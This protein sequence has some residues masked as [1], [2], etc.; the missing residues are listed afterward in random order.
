MSFSIFVLGPVKMSFQPS[1][2]EYFNNRKRPAVDDLKS[3]SNPSKVLIVDGA[4]GSVDVESPKS[5]GS[6]VHNAIPKKIVYTRKEASNLPSKKMKLSKTG[7]NSSKGSKGS[8]DGIQT[9][10]RKSL[11]ITNKKTVEKKENDQESKISKV[12]GNTDFYL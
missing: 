12:S 5:N 4:L 2:V 6:L 10:I 8:I 9:D 11:L 1:V 7:R 3:A